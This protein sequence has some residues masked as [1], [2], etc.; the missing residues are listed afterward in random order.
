[1][2]LCDN[3]LNI[4]KLGIH[5][6]ARGVLKNLPE[7]GLWYSVT[8]TEHVKGKTCIT[9]D[10]VVALERQGRVKWFYKLSCNVSFAG[11]R[12]WQGCEVLRHEC[13]GW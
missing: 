4:M 6:L 5:R 2:V 12:S 10:V 7:D 3:M 11:K 9:V 8:Y 1:M 13:G